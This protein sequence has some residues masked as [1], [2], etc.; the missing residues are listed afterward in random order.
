MRKQML[1]LGGSPRYGMKITPAGNMSTPG[2]K[3]LR[4]LMQTKI[5]GRS[6]LYPIWS[7]SFVDLEPSNRILS[8]YM[9]MDIN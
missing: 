2:Y 4:R 7:H 6:T 1:K 9:H 5:L 3:F 8:R